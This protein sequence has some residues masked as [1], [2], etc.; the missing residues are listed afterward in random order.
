LKS[1]KRNKIMGTI[2]IDINKYLSEEEKKSIAIDV[3]KER[4]SKDLFKGCS[5]TVQSDSEIQRIIGNISHA[6]VMKEVQKHIPDCEKM[7]KSKT[8]QAL[9][10]EDFS[11]Q[12][13]KKKDA[14]GGEESLAVTYIKEVVQASRD[15]FKS[16]IKE[17]IENYDFKS[18]VS[19]EI[20][21][22]FN[23]MADTIYNLSD[24]FSSRK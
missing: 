20:S 17:T 21:K 18:E 11:Y 10:K 2:E 15:V 4:L 13:F 23:K 6:I 3:F 22:E 19:E 5:G 16:K 8:I 7:I 12:I 24:L 1:I 14:W 9:E